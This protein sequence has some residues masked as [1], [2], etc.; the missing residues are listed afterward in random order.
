MNAGIHWLYLLA[1]GLCEIGWPLGLKLSD[2]PGFRIWGLALSLI[3]LSAS[4]WLLWLALKGIPLGTAYAVWT[5]IGAAGT[6]V[7]GVA[8][9]GD[10]TSRCAGWASHSSCRGSPASRR[11]EFRPRLIPAPARLHDMHHREHDR[12]LHQHAHDRRQRRP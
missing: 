10:P 2:E 4:A 11:R 1:A 9:F 7:L 6:F 3:C 12:H 8:V 5:G